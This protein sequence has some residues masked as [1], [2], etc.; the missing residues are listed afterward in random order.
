MSKVLIISR[1]KS[2]AA[3]LAAAL[4]RGGFEPE[5]IRSP[6]SLARLLP[7]N[8]RVLILADMADEGSGFPETLRAVRAAAGPASQIVA[9]VKTQQLGGGA[10]DGPADDFLLD[11]AP[12]AELAERLRRRAAALEDNGENLI[13]I[14]D[15]AID[16]E[17]CEARVAG[18]PLSLTFKEFELLRFLAE[19]PGKIYSRQFLLKTIWEYDWYGGMRTVDVHIR[20]LRSKLGVDTGTLITTVRGVGYGIVPPRTTRR[21]PNPK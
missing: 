11:S 2:R 5:T 1:N 6:G 13:R 9:V 14:A 16:T 18:R 8:S 12:K 17:R 19:N 3:A 20:R 15:L 21:K 4:K 10:L 7:P